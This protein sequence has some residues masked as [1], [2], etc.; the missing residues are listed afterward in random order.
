MANKVLGKVNAR[1]KYLARKSK[2][3][4]K[5]SMKVLANSHI[6]CHFDNPRTSWFGGLSK[7][8]KGK[9]Q[10]AHNKLFRVVLKVIPCTHIGRSCIQELNWLPV[11]SIPD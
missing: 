10:I 4:D 3:L 5:D 8:M 11:D 1:M 2:L 9:L 7:L 6:Q